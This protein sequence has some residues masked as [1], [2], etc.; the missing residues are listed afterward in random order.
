MVSTKAGCR[1]FDLDGNIIIGI[2]EGNVKD[3]Q[4]NNVMVLV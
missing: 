4:L 1:L 2:D 3:S